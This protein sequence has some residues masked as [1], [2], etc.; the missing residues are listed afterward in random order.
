MS[1][2]HPQTFADAD[3]SQMMAAANKARSEELRKMFRQARAYF[4]GFFTSHGEA[5]TQS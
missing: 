5:A 2:K 1:A 3:L 4:A